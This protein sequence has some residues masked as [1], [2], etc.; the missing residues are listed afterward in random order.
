[1]ARAAFWQGTGAVVVAENPDAI[2]MTGDFD[3][4]GWQDLAVVVR[5][6]PDKADK[7]NDPL[8][9]KNSSSAFSSCLVALIIF[10]Q[11]TQLLPTLYLSLLAL[12]VRDRS[13]VKALPELLT[14]GRIG[15]TWRTA[16]PSYWLVP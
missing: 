15:A 8:W 4:D 11:S 1:M 2:V 3:G 9:S 5:C 12:G 14:I 10:Q 13:R 6:A 7:V 16:E